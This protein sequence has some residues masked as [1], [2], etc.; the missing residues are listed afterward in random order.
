MG[1]EM[2]IRDRLTADVFQLFIKYYG[3]GFAAGLYIDGKVVVVNRHTIPTCTCSSASLAVVRSTQVF[4]DDV[5][6]KYRVIN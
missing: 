6:F 5:I 2:C 3:S 1:S 4:Q